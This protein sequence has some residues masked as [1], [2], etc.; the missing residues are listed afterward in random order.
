MSKRD[1]TAPQAQG[2]AAL[3]VTLGLASIV[4]ALA[5]CSDAGLQPKNTTQRGEVD[6]LLR[7]SG[8]VCTSAPRD[9]LFPVKIMFVVD[10]SGSMQF[11]DPSTATASSCQSACTAA[12]VAA[13]QCTALCAGAQNPGRQAAVKAVID[14]YKNNPAVSFSVI[15]FNGRVTVNGGAQ[16]AGSS[17][18]N[19]PGVLNQA[20]TSLNQAEITTD[21]Q[22]ALSTAFTLLEKD[23]IATDPVQRTRTKYVIIFLTDG[24]PN[25]VCEKGCGNDTVDLGGGIVVDSWCD[26]PRDQ[27]CGNFGA[28]GDLCNSMQQWY[29]SMAEPCQAYNTEDL[30]TQRVNEIMDLGIRFGVGEIRFHTAFLFVDGLSQAILDLFA[31]DKAKSESLLKRMAKAGQGEYRSFNSGQA[32]DFLSIGYATL[33]RP[34]GMTNFLVSNP[35]A[36][37]GDGKL[38]IDSDGDGVDDETEFDVHLQ[39]DR[40]LVDSD[41]DGYGDQIEYQRRNKGFHPGDAKLPVRVCP[42]AERY[43]TDGDG[44]RDCEETL[45]GTNPAIADSDRDRVPDGLEVR[46]GTDPTTADANVDQDFDG[47]LA[48]EEISLHSRPTVADADFQSNF[49]YIYKVSPARE[50]LDRRR[51]Y[52]FDVRQVRLVT[53]LQVGAAGTSGYNEVMVYFGEGLADDPRDYGEFRAACVRAQYVAPSLKLPA[54][55]KVE[56]KETD[57]YPLSE[58]LAARAAAENDPES[59]PCVG[60]ALP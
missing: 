3:M 42:P 39:M 6:D 33:A 37:P 56:L 31:V 58:L 24:A 10:T 27:W 48:G 50:Q 20:M 59:D 40:I 53:T 1:S 43:D 52:S 5:A 60:V 21:Y 11:T 2:R 15:R 17:F 26:V 28:N 32:I 46:F 34:F 23:L 41:G 18:T 55:G 4:T 57:F 30:I 38:L 25:P 45:L 9:Q 14:R 16:G 54:S 49:K 29:P 36:R 22:G 8:E 12:G 35:H 47:R 51:C 13:A 44:L 7:I 19:D